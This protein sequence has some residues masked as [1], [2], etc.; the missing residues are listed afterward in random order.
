MVERAAMV[1]QF[2]N[3]C[4]TMDIGTS[5]GECTIEVVLWNNVVK[6]FIPTTLIRDGIR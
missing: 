4:S 3:W 1:P 2:A 6:S 5:K